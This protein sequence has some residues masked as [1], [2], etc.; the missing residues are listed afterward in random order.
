M[1]TTH[2]ITV[3]EFLRQP[4]NGRP[5]ELV[6]GHIVEMNPLGALHGLICGRLVTAINNLIVPRQLGSA[7]SNDTGVITGRNP[8]SVRGPDVAFYS[9]TRYPAEAI[10]DGYPPVPPE[11]VFEVL[12][13]SDRWPE[14]LQKVGEYL[15]AG[16]DCVCV[17]NAALRQVTL[18]RSDQSVLV[19]HGSEAIS[20]PE[21]A[22]D[23]ALSLAEIWG[24]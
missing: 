17:V 13:P 3:E 19:Y 20:L 24:H 12:S 21:I 7:F 16:V 8:D 22:S 14:T 23:C 18:F 6:R 4:A 15:N 5:T 9:L 11:V 1:A 2:L 10:S